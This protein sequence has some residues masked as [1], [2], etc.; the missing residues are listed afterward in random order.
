M[1]GASVGEGRANFAVGEVE[2]PVPAG[3]AVEHGPVGGSRG[4]G[5]DEVGRPW[6]MV[7]RDRHSSRAA[8]A[9]RV[10]STAS[11]AAR[12]AVAVG[13]DAVFMETHPDPDK[14]LSDG[15]NMVVLD[16]LETMLRHLTIL[17]ETVLAFEN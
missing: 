4:R 17:R 13:C 16:R 1:A 8:R 7:L 11:L 6:R 15:P 2:R 14:G 3:P 5:C 12:A 10:S 9:R